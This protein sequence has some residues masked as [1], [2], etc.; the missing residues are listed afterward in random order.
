M[1]VF[2]SG[3]LRPPHAPSPEGRADDR[4]VSGVLPFTTIVARGR[5]QQAGPKVTRPGDDTWMS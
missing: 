5:W 1:K 4:A 3:P 2:P